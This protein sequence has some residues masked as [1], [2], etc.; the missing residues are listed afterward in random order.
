[1]LLHDLIPSL[2]LACWVIFV[3]KSSLLWKH[4]VW[5]L[6][7]P[8]AYF[9]YTLLRGAAL[10]WY[11][12]PFLDANAFG[13]FASVDQCGYAAG[14]FLLMGLLAVGIGCWMGRTTTDSGSY[15]N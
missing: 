4:A 14:G 9:A 12:Y 6:A 5:W 8:A 15:S 10:G 7:Y 13:I 2:Y 11:P 1:V 3:R